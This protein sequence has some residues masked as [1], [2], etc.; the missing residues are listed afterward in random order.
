MKREE[1]GNQL[2]ALYLSGIFHSLS[3]IGWK[4][5]LYSFQQVSI[6]I[7]LMRRLKCF[8][9]LCSLQ[10]TTAGS[11]FRFAWIQSLR[12]FYFNMLH[13]RNIFWGQ[14]LSH[15]CLPYSTASF[16]RAK[17]TFALF[18]ALFSVLAQFLNHSKC[19]RYTKWL[20]NPVKH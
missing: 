13:R 1:R 7:L 18:A 12:T 14:I 3:Q 8:K 16:M 5:I 4:I 19:S 9:M 6:C 2:K 20:N 10:Q 15:I 11:D 17:I